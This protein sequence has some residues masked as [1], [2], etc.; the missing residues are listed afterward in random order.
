MDITP[1]RVA[2]VGCGLIGRRR[3]EV[4][5]RSAADKLV[6]VSDIDKNR[7]ASLSRERGCLATAECRRGLHN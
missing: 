2:V 5:N 3:A 6:V 1:L 7:A 4:V